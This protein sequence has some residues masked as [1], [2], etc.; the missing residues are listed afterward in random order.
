MT[1]RNNS[2][3]EQVVLHELKQFLPAL[4]PGRTFT[5]R[6]PLQAFQHLAFHDALRQASGMLGYHTSLS[7]E[8]YRSLYN[9][10]RVKPG[11]LEKVLVEKKGAANTFEWQDKV[12]MKKFPAQTCAAAR[13][14]QLRAHWQKQYK[15]DPDAR[16]HPRLLRI[17]GNY[18]D[19]GIADWKFPVRGQGFLDSMREVESNSFVSAFNT[20]RARN[21][22]LHT[23]PSISDLLAVIVGDETLFKQY[24]F[25]Q[26]FAHRGWSG[27]VATLESGG[28]NLPNGSHITLRELIVF[29]LLM[30]IDVLDD[31]LGEH[32]E[33]LASRLAELPDDLFAPVPMDE[34]SEVLAI[35]Q[36]AVEW[37]YYE[38]ILAGLFHNPEN[39]PGKTGG[40]SSEVILTNAPDSLC[41]VGRPPVFR[42]LPAGHRAFLN[43]YEFSLDPE[44][45]VLE[46][47]LE[48]VVPSLGAANLE[49]Y[50]SR[51]SQAG[52]D[53]GH[54]LTDQIIGLFGMTGSAR[55]DLRT[56]LPTELTQDLEP[57]RLLCVV[58]QFPETVMQV[59]RRLN[60]S[61]SWL[62]NEWVHLV[63]VDPV[64][65]ELRILKKGKMVTYR[66]LPA[67]KSLED[68]AH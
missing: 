30:E 21:L 33:P 55:G 34:K 35:W 15:T 5:H 19:H 52:A 62:V 43:G 20:P 58:E 66:R 7:L 28:K 3:D 26:Q 51:T 12:L 46:K 9:S 49:Y 29:E 47:I 31:R 45:E 53:V 27:L 63:T 16:V 37:S 60:A 1:A 67:V 54:A 39:S 57:M 40:Q 50:F 25:D 56:G 10:K 22:L 14:G 8:E 48:T 41:I 44:G 64:S 32:W 61:R 42:N 68:A 6:N 4:V 65:R 36:E 38:G 11:V 17:L 59:I 24:L 18:L 23:S 13:I 2:F